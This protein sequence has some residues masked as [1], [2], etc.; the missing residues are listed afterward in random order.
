MTAQTTM[1]CFEAAGLGKAPF[2]YLGMEYQEISYGQRVIGSAG[3]IQVTTK[4]GSTCDFCG[5]YIVNIFNV[6]SSDGKKFKVGCECIRKTDDSGLIRAVDADVKKMERE[7]RKVKKEAKVQK[8]KAICETLLSTPAI[9]AKL[10]EQKHPSPYFASEG[11]TLLDWAKWMM[12]N[13]NFASLAGT[14]RVYG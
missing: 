11:K 13:R 5:T 4:P 12:E 3:G 6:G 1:H 10:S 7:K 2:R 8:D 14:L 9:R